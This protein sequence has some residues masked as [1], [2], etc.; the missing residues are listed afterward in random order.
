[1]D[2]VVNAQGGEGDGLGTGPFQCHELMPGD[3]SF[4]MVESGVKADPIA[5]TG[6]KNMDAASADKES[7]SNVSTVTTPNGDVFEVTSGDTFGLISLVGL[8]AG[9]NL[10]VTDNAWTGTKFQTNEGTL[11]VSGQRRLKFKT[12][13][14]S[15][16][17]SFS[18]YSLTYHYLL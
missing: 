9:L 18:K 7:A 17:L 10:Y 12:V 14:F 4:F 16:P 1:M 11:R 5:T 13:T 2:S 3:I 8:P 6:S 15:L